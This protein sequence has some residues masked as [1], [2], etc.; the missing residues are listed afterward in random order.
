MC[1][2]IVSDPTALHNSYGL[3]TFIEDD[4]KILYY[5]AYLFTRAN[6][7]E[8]RSIVPKSCKTPL[9]PRLRNLI[10]HFSE[11]GLLPQPVIQQ[12]KNIKIWNIPQA[13]ETR[14]NY[15]PDHH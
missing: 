6:S 12:Q 14:H 15:Q 2:I 1:V 10:V 9:T 5:T 3:N 7:L 13:A 8:V 4:L 11:T